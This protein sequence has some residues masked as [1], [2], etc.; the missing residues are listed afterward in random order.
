MFFGKLG[1]LIPAGVL[2]QLLASLQKKLQSRSV[3]WHLLCWQDHYFN[4]S[5]PF[6]IHPF[7]M[8]DHLLILLVFIFSH[9]KAS[10][11]HCT[12]RLLECN[13]TLVSKL[14]TH[15]PCKEGLDCI[16]ASGACEVTTSRF[17]REK[18]ESMVG[19]CERLERKDSNALMCSSVLLDATGDGNIQDEDSEDLLGGLTK[20]EKWLLG[21]IAV[22]ILLCAILVFRKF[23]KRCKKCFC[24]DKRRKNKADSFIKILTRQIQGATPLHAIDKDLHRIS[25]LLENDPSLADFIINNRSDLLDRINDTVAK[26]REIRPIFRGVSRIPVELSHPDTPIYGNMESVARRKEEKIYD[27]LP[28]HLDPTILQDALQATYIKMKQKQV[29]EREMKTRGDSSMIRQIPGEDHLYE[30]PAQVHK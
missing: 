8:F 4:R 9:G 23:Y 26:R 20:N 17:T 15:D 12:A 11:V 1:N 28:S 16:E 30:T 21:G 25:R 24:N 5:S 2:L 7:N 22:G 10:S 27:Q 6:G 18:C 14:G 3:V 13:T 19:I 29:D